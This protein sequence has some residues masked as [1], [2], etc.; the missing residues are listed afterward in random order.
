MASTVPGSFFA[1]TGTW[2]QSGCIHTSLR[3]SRLRLAGMWMES[4]VREDGL[5]G[6]KTGNIC[7]KSNSN[8]WGSFRSC[9]CAWRSER[10][11]WNKAPGK[12]PPGKDTRVSWRVANKD[13]CFGGLGYE[14]ET[15]WQCSGQFLFCVHEWSLVILKRSG[16]GG[17]KCLDPCTI[18]LGPP[19]HALTLMLGR[20]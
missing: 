6:N 8:C 19:T 13:F 20:C 18:S 2:T 7:L 15:T 4:M 14:F 12:G 11:M 1:L 9:S 16:T 5:K 10:N 17:V 3:N